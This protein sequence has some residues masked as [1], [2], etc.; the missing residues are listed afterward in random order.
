MMMDEDVPADLFR[1]P[2]NFPVEPS[3]GVSFS[4]MLTPALDSA[5][6]EY[7]VFTTDPPPERAGLSSKFQTVRVVGSA[8]RTKLDGP[9]NVLREGD[10]HASVPLT[11]YLDEEA[12]AA[13][14]EVGSERIVMQ[15]GEF[16]RFVKV[17]FDL[18]PAGAM[19]LDGIVYFYLRS[20]SLIHI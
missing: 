20:L 17:S 13:I 6:G 4:G 2:I 11:V 1:M 3:K 15:P 14:V 12:D 10:P 18:L 16:S 5:Y 9:A 8:V 19:A 7:N